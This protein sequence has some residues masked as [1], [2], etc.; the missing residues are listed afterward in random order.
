MNKIIVSVQRTPL[1]KPRDDREQ[2]LFSRQNSGQG[3]LRQMANVN[4]TPR[5]Q[6]FS[7]PVVYCTALLKNKYLYVIFIHNNCFELFLDAY[8]LFREI[9]N[10]K[11]M[12]AVY[13]IKT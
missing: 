1:K 9:K 5:D 13:S 12:F 10:L 11:L 7:L 6:V 3:R 8:F 4:F 2:S